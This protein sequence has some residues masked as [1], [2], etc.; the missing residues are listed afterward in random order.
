[1]R[2][3]LLMVSLRVVPD[4]LLDRGFKFRFPKL[5]DALADLSPAKSKRSAG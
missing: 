3:E 5:A 2:N 4:T 1:M